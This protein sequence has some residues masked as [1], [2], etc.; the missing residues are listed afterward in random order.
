VS[1]FSRNVVANLVGTGWSALVQLAAVPV[2]ISLVG[3]ASFALVGFHASLVAALA[4]L[5]LGLSPNLTR[6][7]AGAFVAGADRERAADSLRTYEV[8]FWTVGTCLGAAVALCAPLIARY[9]LSSSS[10]AQ[11]EIENSV[12]LMGLLLA[13]RWPMAP[14]VSTL[15]GL[16]RQVSINAVNAATITAAYGAGIAVIAWLSPSIVAFFGWYCACA[17]VQ[18]VTLR[19]L[20]VRALHRQSRAGRF[21]AGTLIDNWQFSLGMSAI[22]LTAVVLVQGDKLILAKLVTLEEFGYYSVALVA[23]GAMYMVMLPVFNAALPRLCE[24]VAAAD[25]P[26]LRAAFTFSCQVMHAL[27]VPL[28][29][30]L[31]LFPHEVLLL[32]TRN[33]AL[34]ARSAPLLVLLAGGTLL[35]GFMN[36]PYALQMARANTAIGLKINLALCGLLVPAILVL[37]SRMGILGGAMVSPILNALYLLFALPPTY[38]QCLGANDWPD[39]YFDLLRRQGGA[40]LLLLGLRAVISPDGP[41][42]FLAIALAGALCASLVVSILCTPAARATLL[43]P[44]AEAM[45]KSSP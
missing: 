19:A 10:L 18:L 8:V 7:M 6:R 14:Y 13:L 31:M 35:N 30:F 5:D 42:V 1:A 21:L 22:S 34:A 26:G 17:A 38:R 32:W 16:Q 29:V 12:R 44:L 45:R 15:Q 4:I 28:G 2:L 41:P 25:E 9:W 36:V 37:T 20:A 23:V 43:G 39:F 33:P 27:L 24:R 11:S 40:V 3:V